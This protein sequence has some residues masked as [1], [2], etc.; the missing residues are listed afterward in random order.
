M[1]LLV[2][3]TA[4]LVLYFCLKFWPITVIRPNVQ[5]YKVVTEK[6]RVGSNF[7][8]TV[9]ACK[10]TDSP[11][12]VSRVFVDGIRYP[13]VTST[14]NVKKGCNKTNVSIQVPNYVEPGIYHLE[15]NVVYKINAL[16]NDTYKFSTE[17]F[18]VIPEEG[19][20]EK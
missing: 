14:N 10:F 7:I 3:S 11:A 20:M 17:G 9:D 15:L 2:L 4:L 13:S 19:V 18:E 6:V 16:R 1:P 8:Y 5:P 12:T